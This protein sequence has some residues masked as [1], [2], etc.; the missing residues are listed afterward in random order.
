MNRRLATV[1]GD[2]DVV[3][4]G[5]CPFSFISEDFEDLRALRVSGDSYAYFDTN[6]VSESLSAH[7]AYPVPEPARVPSPP[8]TPFNYLATN[9]KLESR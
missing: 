4:V 8:P 3:D 9:N 5:R 6:P 2:T 1:P 7:D